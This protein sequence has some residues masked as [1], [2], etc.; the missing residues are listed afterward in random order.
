MRD[1]GSWLHEDFNDRFAEPWPRVPDELHPLAQLPH[2]YNAV[3]EQ[4]PYGS[5]RPVRFMRYRHVVNA[6][7]NTDQGSSEPQALISAHFRT[8]CAALEIAVALGLRLV[9]PAAFP[10]NKLPMFKPYY[11]QEAFTAA[12]I[13]TCTFDYF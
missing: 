1:R 5:G 8:L 6:T 7:S 2:G 10:C 13:E 11:M 3:G 12:E 4:D 9:L